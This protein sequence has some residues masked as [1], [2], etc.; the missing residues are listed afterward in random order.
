MSATSST[1]SGP[2]LSE[3]DAVR[4]DDLA[5]AAELG[6]ASVP[7]RF[8]VGG[9]SG[10]QLRARCRLRRICAATGSWSGARRSRRP[11]ARATSSPP[12]S[13]GRSR[14]R[15]RSAERRVPDQEFVAG[16]H[17][18]STPRNGR[19][20]LLVARRGARPARMTA[21]LCRTSPSRSSSPQATCM[22]SRRQAARAPRRGPGSPVL[23]ERL[24]TLRTCSPGSAPGS[25]SSAQ[26]APAPPRGGPDRRRSCVLLAELGSIWRPR[27]ASPL[28]S[29]GALRYPDRERTGL[30]DSGSNVC[31]QTQPVSSVSTG[32]T[33]A[34][35]MSCVRGGC[36]PAAA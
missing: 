10:S 24:V 17:E 9:R 26:P 13:G 7:T 25:T 3:P 22:P 15:P 21:A 12:G 18:R 32:R 28:L 23:A 6:P 35:Q 1:S 16:R 4:V 8:A 30:P 31:R 34:P 11:A 29:H 27:R 14:S 5:P 20:G 19:W 2:G 33:D 36:R